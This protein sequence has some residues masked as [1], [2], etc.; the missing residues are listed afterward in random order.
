MYADDH[1][2]YKVGNQI[3][4]VVDELIIEKDILS[5]W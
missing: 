2:L 1:Q 3:Q 4:G 5:N